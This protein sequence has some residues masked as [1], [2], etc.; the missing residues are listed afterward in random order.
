MYLEYHVIY[1][2]DICIRIVYWS[3]NGII[4][5]YYQQVTIFITL[6]GKYTVVISLKIS[7]DHKLPS[8]G[9][10]TVNTQYKIQFSISSLRQRFDLKVQS[11]LVERRFGDWSAVNGL[12]VENSSLLSFARRPPSLYLVCTWSLYFK[13]YFLTFRVAC[14][15]G[16]VSC[17][18]PPSFRSMV[19]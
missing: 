8:H 7:Q 9:L 11:Q 6:E 17:D 16:M 3:F 12:D 19:I 14:G 2:R 18:V 13:K 1:F 10:F 4:I 15:H 5:I